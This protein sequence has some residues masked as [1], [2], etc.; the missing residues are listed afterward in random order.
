MAEILTFCSPI[1]TRQDPS[2]S[3]VRNR[4]Y[5]PNNQ[6]S[7]RKILDEGR[8]RTERENDKSI[9][10]K[11]L[12]CYNLSVSQGSYYISPNHRANSNYGSLEVILD[13]SIPRRLQWNQRIAQAAMD[14]LQ[15]N[16]YRLC[17]D[18][19]PPPEAGGRKEQSSK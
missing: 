19:M 12:A 3:D 2:A 10:C 17:T 8:S 9:M 16:L 4:N 6:R 1:F 15:T 7:R 5:S 18:T 13:I 14:E 11:K